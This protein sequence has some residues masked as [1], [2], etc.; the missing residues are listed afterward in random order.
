MPREDSHKDKEKETDKDF[1]EKISVMAQFYRN[2]EETSEM[3]LWNV[4]KTKI[5]NTNKKSKNT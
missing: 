3:N 5:L 2:L 1:R 4:I